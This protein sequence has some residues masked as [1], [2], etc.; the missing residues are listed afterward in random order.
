[1]SE[2]LVRLKDGTGSKI[3]PPSAYEGYSFRLRLTPP[4]L[5]RLTLLATH[6]MSESHASMWYDVG[7]RLK[8][9]E[10][11]ISLVAGSWPSHSARWSSA[12]KSALLEGLSLGIR[13]V[14]CGVSPAPGGA[15]AYTPFSSRSSSVDGCPS[16]PAMRIEKEQPSA[17]GE[18]IP[19]SFSV[20][21]HLSFDKGRVTRCRL[22]ALPREA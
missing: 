1:M 19:L 18:T 11:G 7:S 2:R 20:L 6:V 22:R 21:T 9:G 15:E 4:E 8:Q 12:N 16:F 17:D 10:T 3:T 14:D 13:R 5:T